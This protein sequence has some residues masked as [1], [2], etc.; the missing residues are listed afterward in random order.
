MNITYGTVLDTTGRE[1]TE[2]IIEQMIDIIAAESFL[3]Q[4]EGQRI[5]HRIWVEMND[6]FEI[7]ERQLRESRYGDGE[8][9][10]AVETAVRRAKVMGEGHWTTST[11]RTDAE[12]A[13]KTLTWI[14][15]SVAEMLTEGAER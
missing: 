13:S 5:E 2:E 6:L 8:E 11:P 10:L 4:N 12:K 15:G 14:R 1:T 7:V 3:A 9:C